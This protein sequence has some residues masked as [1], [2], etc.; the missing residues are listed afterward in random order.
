MYASLKVGPIFKT[1][2][3][4]LS[5]KSLPFWRSRCK[6]LPSMPLHLIRYVYVHHNLCIMM[7]KAHRWGA[8]PKSW[9]PK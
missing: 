7:I 9:I 3:T 6:N 2:L 1:N 5:V 4:F 8:F